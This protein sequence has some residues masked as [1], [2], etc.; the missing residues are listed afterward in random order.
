MTSNITILNSLSLKSLNKMKELLKNNSGIAS[1]HL[2]YQNQT[3]KGGFKGYKVINSQK[4]KQSILNDHKKSCNLLVTLAFA[5]RKSHDLKTLVP[6]VNRLKEIYS[7]ISDNAIVFSKEDEDLF[8]LIKNALNSKVFINNYLMTFTKSSLKELTYAYHIQEDELSELLE[9]LSYCFI[10]A[11]NVDERKSLYF[12]LQEFMEHLNSK[13]HRFPTLFNHQQL[14]NNQSLELPDYNNNLNYTENTLLKLN[15]ISNDVINTALSSPRKLSLVLSS[16]DN[17][18]SA[19]LREACFVEDHNEPLPKLDNM[20]AMKLLA[21]LLALKGMSQSDIKYYLHYKKLENQLINDTK[22]NY[23]APNALEHLSNGRAPTCLLINYKPSSEDHNANY[24]SQAAAVQEALESFKKLTLPHNRNF[25]DR[26][27]VNILS[28]ENSK[29]ILE[30]M[31]QMYFKIMSDK[32]LIYHESFKLPKILNP[33]EYNITNICAS[34]L[35][36]ALPFKPIMT[37]ID[38]HSDFI[39]LHLFFKKDSI[40]MDLRTGFDND[41]DR[42]Q[43]QRSFD[44]ILA[45][46]SKSKFKEPVYNHRLTNN[47]VNFANAKLDQKRSISLH[48]KNHAI[49]GDY[50]DLGELFTIPGSKQDFSKNYY[51]YDYNNFVQFCVRS[52]MSDT[53]LNTNNLTLKH[54]KNNNKYNKNKEVFLSKSRRFYYG[55]IN[56]FLCLAIQ[57]SFSHIIHDSDLEVRE[58]KYNSNLRPKMPS[59]GAFIYVLEAL[60]SLEGF[61]FTCECGAKNLIL[62]PFIFKNPYLNGQ[63]CNHCMKN[64]NFCQNNTI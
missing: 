45:R 23:N 51:L 22:H 59:L 8:L 43:N 5:L 41:F 38:H 18:L 42:L 9:A 34:V 28:N 33:D 32:G 55:N 6:L 3:R 64:I 1:E 58:S 60:E 39:E 12:S 50:D 16:P 53:H 19:Y 44:N 24:D 15:H 21:Q 35:N 10:A 46:G 11:K 52:L 61:I 47:F 30:Q 49:T 27:L 54:A 17:I 26:S 48:V 37:Q 36:N 13:D 63:S 31:V 2:N 25:E 62:D 40:A 20:S 57:D 7:K 4:F 29:F 14:Y 56:L